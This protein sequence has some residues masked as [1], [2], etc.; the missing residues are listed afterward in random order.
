MSD[1]GK[2]SKPRPFSVSDIE[3][4]DRWEA[5]FHKDKKP[6]LREVVEYDSR[7]MLTAENHLQALAD[8]NQRLGLYD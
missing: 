4:A 7:K 1:G 6:E 8:E 3:Y 2:G 5:I